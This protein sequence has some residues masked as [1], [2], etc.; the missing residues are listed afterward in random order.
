MINREWTP[1][2][3][4]HTKNTTDKYGQKRLLVD[5]SFTSEIF[6][7]QYA[8]RNS[9]RIRTNT[10]I[11]TYIDCDFLALTK[12][13][14]NEEFIVVINCEYYRV[15]YTIPARKYTQV[16][17]KKTQERPEEVEE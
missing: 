17:L 8:I 5:C 2:T 6:V 11:P 15:N 1:C 3:I 13:N 4:L 7:K 10:D 12:D 14:I 9:S 16:F